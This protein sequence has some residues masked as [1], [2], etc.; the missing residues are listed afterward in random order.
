MQAANQKGLNIAKTIPGKKLQ[1]Q[2]IQKNNIKFAKEGGG[3]SSTAKA[4]NSLGEVFD[5]Q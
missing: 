1:R 3:V 2:I 5:S 4:E